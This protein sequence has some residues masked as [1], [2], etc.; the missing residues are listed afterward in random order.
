MTQPRRTRIL[1]Y[2]QHLLGIGHQAR[3]AA[4][5][6]AM[7]RHGMDVYYVTGGFNETKQKLDGAHIVQ[8]PPARSADATFGTLLDETGQP[9]DTAW[10]TRRREALLNAFESIQPD[11]LLIESF[12]FGRRQ[13]RFELLPLLETVAGKIPVAASVRDILVAKNDPKRTQWVIDTVN[14]YFDAIIVHGDPNIAEF[15]GTFPGANAIA[16]RLHY[17]GYVTSQAEHV[18]GGDRSGV[19][20]SAGGGAVGGQLL[21]TAIAARPLSQ[22]S[23]APWQLI[24]GP[25]LPQS[26][27]DA[28]FAPENVTIDTYIEN[29]RGILCKVAV[30]VSQAGYNTVMDLFATRTRS[31]LVPFSQHGETEQSHRAE[32]LARRGDVQI[33]TETQLSPTTLA[34]AIDAALEAPPPDAAG[35]DLGGA[36]RTAEIMAKFVSGRS[37]TRRL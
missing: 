3:A 19:I 4:I 29:F 16:D 24:T 13:F 31:V 25:N 21:R 11:A 35:I 28:L 36:A 22:L 27:R 32:L 34:R 5:T 6:R 17:S 26:D 14:A 33:V 2:V 20:V 23:E 15:G 10:Q 12:P 30:S 9:I 1:F 8:L 37:F 7:R 18:N